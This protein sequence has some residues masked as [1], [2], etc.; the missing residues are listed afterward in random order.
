MKFAATTAQSPL[1][2]LL[3]GISAHRRHHRCRNRFAVASEARVRRR[4]LADR[5]ESLFR[6]LRSGLPDV[7]AARLRA[8]WDRARRDDTGYRMNG[9]AAR[10]SVV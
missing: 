3:D 10:G 4:C 2:G 5:R 6:S 9:V 1:R 8:R 7:P